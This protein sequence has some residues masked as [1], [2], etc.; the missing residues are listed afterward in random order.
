[1]RNITKNYIIISILPIAMLIYAFLNDD[2]ENIYRGLVIITKSNN[3]LTTDY[4]YIAGTSA[5]LIN[6]SVIT[7]LN[8]LL[9][10]K[11]DLRINGFIITAIFLMLGYALMGKTLLNIIPFYIGTYFHAKFL[12]KSY[13]SVVVGALMSTSLAPVVSSIPYIGFI[14][15]IIIS[16][17]FPFVTKH[18]VHFHS[19]Y[20]L[21]NSGL[22]GGMI[23]IVLY[24]V[25][26]A[27]GIEFDLN[28]GYYDKFD[29]RLF[30]LLLMYFIFL[31][32]LGYIRTR[33]NFIKKLLNLYKHT[34]ILVSD[35]IQKDGLE[36]S[37]FNMG[38]LGVLGLLI[39]IY[40]QR[41]NGPVLTGLFALVAFGGF[42]K[43]LKNVYPILIGVIASK[44]IFSHDISITIFLLTVFLSTTLAP[45]AGKFGVI[46]GI[47]AGILF[48][49]T[50]TS[51]GT[52][53]GGINLYN[54]G[55]AAGIVV[56]VYLPI[57]LGIR[58]GIKN[59]KRLRKR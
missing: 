41:L 25:V 23:G 51:V 49:A 12:K 34:G 11:L 43:H 28:N 21:Y 52:V 46:N 53:H 6:A 29:Y 3:I 32:I 15:A 8:I 10:Y 36:I 27:S 13:R 20:S 38:T 30:I 33:K 59:W 24:S 47:I 35:F 40:Y 9:L 4:F 26:K 58:G 2:L 55:L 22:A 57:I 17:I 5:A 42:G 48:Y 31:M 16:F 45:I 39:I 54:S 1:M 14:L 44:Y 56:S 50:V 18:V 37:L 7:L 19:G